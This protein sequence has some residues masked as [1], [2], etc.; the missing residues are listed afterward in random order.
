MRHQVVQHELDSRMKLHLAISWLLQQKKTSSVI[1]DQS[2]A[3]ASFAKD[4][5][6]IDVVSVRASQ[7]GHS[8]PAMGVGINPTKG[9]ADGGQMAQ[10]SRN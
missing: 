10:S 5:S 6:Q 9:A 7:R 2:N 4:V 1:N 8:C 3:Y